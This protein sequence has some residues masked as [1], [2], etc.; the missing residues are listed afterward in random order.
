M[1]VPNA[2]GEGVDGEYITLLDGRGVR[3]SDKLCGVLPRAVLTPWQPTPTF[4]TFFRYVLPA[5][6]ESVTSLTCDMR[7]P[8]AASPTRFRPAPM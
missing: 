4:L 8:A 2:G 5:G 6:I 1:P 7:A 3:N